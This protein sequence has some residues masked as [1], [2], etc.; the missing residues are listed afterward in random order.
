M[1][2]EEA[3]SAHVALRAQR[4]LPIHWATFNLAFHAWS[5]PIERAVGS[6]RAQGIDL[7]TPR[8]GEVV[9]VG[10]PFAS[11]AWWR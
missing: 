11:E 4:M 5:E 2:P 1:E 3:V 10:E 8:I 9:R 7:V 6:A